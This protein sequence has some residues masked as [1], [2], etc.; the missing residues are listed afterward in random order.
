MIGPSL[1]AARTSLGPEVA[2]A[3]ATAGREMSIER[4]IAYALDTPVGV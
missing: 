2:Q 4:A 1:D 3:A